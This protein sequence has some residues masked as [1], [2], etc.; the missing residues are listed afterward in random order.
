METNGKK[1]VRRGC[2][3]GEEEEEKV[4]VALA[5]DLTHAWPE[6]FKTRWPEKISQAVMWGKI[7]WMCSRRV[8]SAFKSGPTKDDTHKPKDAQERGKDTSE[9]EIH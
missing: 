9:G 4:E 7:H 5:E 6:P 1:I 8:R 2:Y 3:K